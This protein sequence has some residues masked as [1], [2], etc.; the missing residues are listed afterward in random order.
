MHPYLIKEEIRVKK[1]E[2]TEKRIKL[3][4]RKDKKNIS[5]T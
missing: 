3:R 5:Q 4:R 1:E 2:S